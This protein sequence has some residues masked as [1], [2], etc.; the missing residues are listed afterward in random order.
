MYIPS[1]RT[2]L[3]ALVAVGGIASVA[4]AQL[5]PATVVPQT[6][7]VVKWPGG[8][9]V[10]NGSEVIVRSTSPNGSSTNLVTGSG[11]GFGNKIVVSGGAGGVTIVKNARNGIGNQLITD[12]DDLLLDLDALLGNVKPAVPVVP[13]GQPNPAPPIPVIPQAD[14]NAP[15][16]PPAVAP[17]P[18][19][20][21][22]APMT[23][24]PSFKGK[25]SP[26]WTQKTFSD[27][28]DCNL[29]WSPAAKLWFRYGSDDDTYRPVPTQPAP[30]T[31]VK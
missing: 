21:L 22:P 16:A 27:A 30:P 24:P 15:V 6:P 10:M 17:A 29:Y 19:P 28:Y 13:Q 9:M 23:D 12:P 2:G 1:L 26:F 14:P 5:P 8:Y 18:M 20:V 31:D 25:A 3:A 11:N 7:Q 4:N